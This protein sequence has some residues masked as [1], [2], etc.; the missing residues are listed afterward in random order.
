MAAH[1]VEAGFSPFAM[2]FQIR[3]AVSDA[4][5]SVAQRTQPTET[6]TKSAK[7]AMITKSRLHKFSAVFEA[8]RSLNRAL[9]GRS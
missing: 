1:L 2:G 8:S 7:T 3:Q 6:F 4:G 9:A 5:R